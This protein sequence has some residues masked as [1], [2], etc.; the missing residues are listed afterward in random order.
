MLLLGASMA[1]AG[2]PALVNYQGRLT[3]GTNLVQGVVAVSLRL[4]DSPAGGT[5]LYEDSNAVAVVDGL[6]STLMGD[7]TTAGD[8][9]AA[10]ANTNVH[11]ETVIQGIPLVPRERVASVAYALRAQYAE[12]F[13]SN[14]VWRTTGNAG[15]STS[16][17]FLGTTDAQPLEIRVNNERA[18]RLEPGAASP[19][20]IGGYSSNAVPPGISGAFI[21]GGGG[22]GGPNL[23]ASN[24]AVVVGGFNNRASGGWAFV[25]GGSGNLAKGNQSA[26]AGGLGNTALTNGAFVGGGMSNVAA[27]LYAVV[28]G[29]GYD[30][31]NQ[32]GNR[33]TGPASFIGGGVGNEALGMDSAVIGGSWNTA[34]EM[35]AA[36][37]GGSYNRADGYNAFVGGGLSNRALG[38]SSSVAGGRHNEAW[39]SD[40]AVPGGAF[41]FAKGENSL[42]AGYRAKALHDGTFVWADT[43]EADFASS[44]PGQFLIRASGGVFQG[45]ADTNLWRITG[46]KVVTNADVAGYVPL[47]VGAEL[48]DVGSNRLYRAVGLTAA[49]W[50]GI[51]LD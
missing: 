27:G 42:A 8:L 18:M 45:I 26:V 38:G 21:G 35:F 4:Y 24:Y 30:G 48:L 32:A 9:A 16:T 43:N 29:G 3:D 28:G 14:A 7:D 10:L 34:G 22:P 25:G 15:T 12:E 51:N 23:A 39:G 1:C 47:H 20:L 19:N 36:V 11:L 49:D 44:A 17:H 2:V 6:Y 37:G 13:V 5:L 31:I 33:A 46:L 50:R 40:S 41:N